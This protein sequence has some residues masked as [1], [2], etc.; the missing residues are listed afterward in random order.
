M[1]KK[2]NEFLRWWKMHI[3]RISSLVIITSIVMLFICSFCFEKIITLEIMNQWVSLIVGIT[4]FLL[5]IISLMLSF[6]NVEKAEDIQNETLESI[7]ESQKELKIELQNELKKMQS[8]VIASIRT[9]PDLTAQ[10]IANFRNE[11]VN[12]VEMHKPKEGD[13]NG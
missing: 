5:S 7:K 2:I 10:Q 6:Y 4:A 8:E 9:V 13:L 3:L 11:G 12:M 1:L